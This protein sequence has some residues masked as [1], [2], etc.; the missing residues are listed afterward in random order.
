MAT[1]DVVTPFHVQ[2]HVSDQEARSGLLEQDRI[3]VGQALAQ[4]ELEEIIG[5]TKRWAKA[6]KLNRGLSLT[7]PFFDDQVM[8]IRWLD[9]EVIPPGRIPFIPAFVVLAARRE[10]EK[11]SCN[12]SLTPT[13]RE[14][15]LAMLRMLE[16]AFGR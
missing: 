10:A 12:K 7:I 11:A 9:L 8:E 1:Q 14:H 16:L 3:R 2:L 5:K 4:I 6:G 15:V 13:T